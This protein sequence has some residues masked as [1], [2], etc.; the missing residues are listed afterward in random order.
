MR[1]LT[2]NSLGEIIDR[3]KQH[4]KSW[5]LL[6]LKQLTPEEK[7]FV[8][9]VYARQDVSNNGQFNVWGKITA[10]GKPLIRLDIEFKERCDAHWAKLWWAVFRREMREIGLKVELMAETK[11]DDGKHRQVACWEDIT[12]MSPAKVKQAQRDIR[13]EV[14]LIWPL[15]GVCVS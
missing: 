2:V 5:G 12:T 7:R 10:K 1:K 11:D 13:K 3:D 15:A 14:A 4:T 6:E 8:K 9:A